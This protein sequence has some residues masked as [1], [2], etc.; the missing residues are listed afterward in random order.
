MCGRRSDS[1]TLPEPTGP[2]DDSFGYRVTEEGMKALVEYEERHGK[3]VLRKVSLPDMVAEAL[4]DES[5]RQRT[6]QHRKE[7][8]KRG[9]R[10][11]TVCGKWRRKKRVP[12]LRLMGLWLRR[13]GF[14]P[15]R[16]CEVAVEAGTLTIRAI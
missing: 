13:A 2:T 3:P 8:R 6:R 14:D 7:A 5:W 10:L 1:T 15:G 9:R 16:Q 11:V 4:E 12:D